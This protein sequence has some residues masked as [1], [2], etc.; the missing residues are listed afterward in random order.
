MKSTFH[1]WTVPVLLLAAAVTGAARCDDDWSLKPFS[2]VVTPD[3][4]TAYITRG[5]VVEDRPFQSTRIRGDVELGPFGKIGCWN[6]SRN[7]LSGHRQNATRRAFTEVDYAVFW[8]YD[9]KLAEDWR[10]SSELSRAWI[11]FP[12]FHGA[13]QQAKRDATMLE[14]RSE[15]ALVNPYLTPFWLMRRSVHPTDWMYIRTGVRR[16]FALTE[17][18]ALVPCFFTETGN[19]IFFEQRYG[20]R[21]D[22]LRYHRGIM[23]VNGE[24]TLEWRINSHITSF[25]SLQQF[26]VVSE[27][28]RRAVSGRSHP[29]GRRDLTYG[30]VGLRLS[31]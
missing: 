21:G 29:K 9:L 31:F 16:R 15:Q 20:S 25:A 14:Y 1:T 23:S 28:V 22:G 27:Y 24:L 2:L 26:D 18:L 8:H 11:T 30:T 6:W 5:K 17:S 13:A 10:I 3:V 7:S 4:R 12:G 19:E